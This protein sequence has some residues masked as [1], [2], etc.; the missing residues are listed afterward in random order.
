MTESTS[1]RRAGRSAENAA[2]APCVGHDDATADRLRLA[3]MRLARRLRQQSTQGMTPSQLSALSVIA[4]TGPLTIGELA[5]HEN[6]Q[7]PT[8][9]RVVDA[10]ES[11]GWIERAA[12]ESDRR[13]TRVQVTRKATRELARVRAERNAYLADRLATLGADERSAILAAMPAL[14]T[15]LREMDR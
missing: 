4:A 8:I 15:L 10:L 2:L 9:S 14:E 6:V 5:A 11:A 13:V 1:M 3:V 7:P 12:D